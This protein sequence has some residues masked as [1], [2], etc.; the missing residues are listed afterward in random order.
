MS[1][2]ELGPSSALYDSVFFR[3][4]YNGIGKVFPNELC[5]LDYFISGFIIM[6]ILVNAIL[7][8]AAI[9]IWAERR[10]LGRFQNR[11]G[12]NR[13]G[14]FGLL[15]PIA[16]LVKLLT[17]EDLV[18]RG[19]DK[20]AF[21]LVPIVM[22]MPLILMVAVIPIARNTYLADLSICIL[23]IIAVSSITTIGIFMAGWSSG[24]RYVM[25]GAMRGVAMLISYEIPTVMS[26][27]GVVLLAGSMR[28][29][30]VVNAQ[31]IPFFLVQPLGIFVFLLGISAELNRTPFDVVE[32]ESELTAGYHT[33]YS[34]TKFL[35]MQAAEFGGVIA[36]SGVAATIFLGGWS[37]PF[38][39]GQLGALWF[40]LKVGFF[41]FMF[42]WVRATFPRLRIDQIM[43]FAWKFLFPLALINLFATAIE[44]YGFT[45]E[46]SPGGEEIT[47][48]ELGIITGINIVLAIAAIGLFGEF[49]KERVRPPARTAEVVA[50]RTP[51]GPA[52][53]APTPS[54]TGNQTGEAD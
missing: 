30:D 7:L 24:N 43:A 27:V 42:I 11:V 36:A 46:G 2:C 48:A 14:P 5:A 40:L 41:V 31:T 1:G 6:F 20:L 38:L 54:T 39:S 3:I 23:Y 17:K 28:M 44:V 26:L 21:M 25:F 34:G 52:T 9:F 16:D 35:L 4:I 18:P 8:G 51:F 45:R 29:T 22:V 47:R 37:G 19:A 13:W 12:P 49:I 33:E 15:Q 10:V 53:T 32:A 50:P